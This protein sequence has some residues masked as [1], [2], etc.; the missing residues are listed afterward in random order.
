VKRLA[1]CTLALLA[2]AASTPAQNDPDELI[3]DHFKVH[4]T[5]ESRMLDLETLSDGRLV[6]A[7]LE[8]VPNGNDRVVVMTRDPQTFAWSLLLNSGGYTT[9]ILELSLAVPA[10]L[11]GN[12]KLDRAY[13]ALHMAQNV[14]HP[15]DWEWMGLLS[16]PLDAPW[17]QNMG[18]LKYVAM[19]DKPNGQPGQPATA[20]TMFHPSIAVVPE[21]PG[22][23]SSYRVEMVFNYPET[24]SAQGGSVFRVTSKDF[25]HTIG[26]PVRIAGP[27]QTGVTS[28][29]NLLNGLYFDH[30]SAVSDDQNASLVVAFADRTA[31]VVHVLSGSSGQSK[32][33]PLYSTPTGLNED[34]APVLAAHDQLVYM[35]CLTGDVH[36]AGG[37]R[38]IWYRGASFDSSAWKELGTLH[39]R[40]ATPG[41][42]DLREGVAYVAARCYTDNFGKGAPV[43]AIVVPTSQVMPPAAVIVSQGLVDGVQPRVAVAPENWGQPFTVFGWSTLDWV[44]GPLPAGTTLYID[45]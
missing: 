13:V 24:P 1:A 26:A 40:A 38:L 41:D 37:A 28:G 30:A 6:A 14:G 12:P 2:L 17:P 18:K 5:H 8:H 44:P 32:L 15:T 3:S 10:Q 34:Y 22:D 7:Y 33:T 29:N 16:G 45:P 9:R 43:H 36:P 25:G 11:T 4:W 20:R 27:G 19:P 21:K 42:I 35:T 31:K 39:P 23:F